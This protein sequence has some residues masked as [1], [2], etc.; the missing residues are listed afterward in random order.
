MND[1]DY[2]IKEVDILYKYIIDDNE[3]FDN[4]KQIYAR[5]YNSINGSITCQIGG[6]GQLEIDTS[7]VKAIIKD[8]IDKSVKLPLYIK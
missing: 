8:I 7:E 6:M 5:I 1:R 2:I 4:K 3:K